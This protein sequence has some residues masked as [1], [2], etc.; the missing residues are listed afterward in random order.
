MLQTLDDY[1]RQ[2]LL[3]LTTRRKY[4][5]N[6]T[7]FHEGEPGD[8]MH[9]L[10]RGRVAIRGTTPRGDVAT[11]AVYAS[12]AIY[13]EVALLTEQA[14]RTA[15]VVALEPVEVMVLR[16]VDF[17]ELR[18]RHVKVNEF[19]VALLTSQVQRLSKLLLDAHYATVEQR[20]ARR[21]CELVD[22]Y[23]GH[24]KTTEIPLT[25]EDVAS[26]AGTTRPTLNRVLRE[27]EDSGLI[28]IQRGGF[29]IIDPVGLKRRR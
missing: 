2:E 15:S 14:I 28:S 19:L 25:Q 29:E 26:L 12:G 23:E 5:R 21:L 9:F 6:E 22:I 20:V 8:T 18:Q 24:A 27:F 3:Q 13:G 4:R 1:E 16:R 10:D 11:L 7:I 17:D